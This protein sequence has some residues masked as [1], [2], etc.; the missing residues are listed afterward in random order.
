MRDIKRRRVLQIL[1][2]TPAVAALAFTEAEAEQAATQA[3]AA[4]RTAAATG[5]AYKPKFF[6][7]SEYAT[8]VVLADLIIPKD[9][10]S[11]SASDAGAPEFVDHIV[12]VQKERQVAARGGLAWLDTESRHRFGTSF[13]GATDAQRRLVLDDIAWPKKATPAMST[14]V[15]F[16]TRFRDSIASA[17]Y[18]SAMGWKD[19]QYIGN[20]FNPN[21]NGCPEAATAKLGVSY[22][23]YDAALAAQRGS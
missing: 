14:G 20:T 8:V 4:R 5:T 16:F 2:A 17:F 1:G 9:A 10:R 22:A 3:Q 21:W 23:E 19:L 15:A 7:P 13:V 6:T 11:G 12:S 18:S